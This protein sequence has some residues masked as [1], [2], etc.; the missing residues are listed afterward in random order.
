MARSVQITCFLGCC[1]VSGAT[2]ALKMT[3]QLD[4]PASGKPLCQLLVCCCDQTLRQKPC[5]GKRGIMTHCFGEISTVHHRERM[6]VRTC[7]G[8][9]L[10]SSRPGCRNGYHPYNSFV[11][12]SFWHLGIT[13]S[14]CHRFQNKATIYDR[15][16]KG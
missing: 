4:S 11:V 3:E 16:F 8:K 14:R 1:K 6:A 9:D 13:S 10:Y 15:A 2:G 7:N 5:R 12:A